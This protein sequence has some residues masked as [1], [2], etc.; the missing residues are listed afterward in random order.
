MAE[1]GTALSVTS[2]AKFLNTSNSFCVMISV[3]FTPADLSGAA[4]SNIYVIL[5]TNGNQ[6]DNYLA[7]T[8]AGEFNSGSRRGIIPPGGKVSS[9]LTHGVNFQYVA[10][11][12]AELSEWI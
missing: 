7:S 8:A 6:L 3:G 1:Y 10:V 9:D 11:S 2:T 12:F 5:D 4:N